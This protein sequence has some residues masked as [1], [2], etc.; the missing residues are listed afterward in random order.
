[1]ARELAIPCFLARVAMA[2][3]LVA[4]A[5]SSRLPEATS[6][7][8]AADSE[9]LEKVILAARERAASEA[10]SARCPSSKG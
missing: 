1:M 8:G 10:G 4:A 7:T 3:S 9:G 6:A 2:E 5:E